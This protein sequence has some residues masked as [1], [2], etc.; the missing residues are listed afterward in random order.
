MAIAFA[1]CWTALPPPRALAETFKWKDEKGVTHISSTPP[2][3]GATLVPAAADGRPGAKLSTFAP[4]Y[5]VQLQ[6]QGSYTVDVALAPVEGAGGRTWLEGSLQVWVFGSERHLAVIA[7]ASA[8]GLDPAVGIDRD[9]SGVL[10]AEEV[11]QPG[12]TWAVQD[13]VVE[14][15]AHNPP[16]PTATFTVSRSPEALAARSP[17]AS[18]GDEEESLAGALASGAPAP[19][20]DQA[21]LEGRTVSIRDYRGKVLLIDFW[22]T[23]CGPCRRDVPELVKVYRRF[24][25]R[26]FEIVGVSLDDQAAVVADFIAKE[27]MD[28]PQICDGNGFSSELARR[29]DVNAIPS[30]FLVDPDGKLV[31]GARLHGPSAV[32]EEVGRLLGK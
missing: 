7:G 17:V 28:W 10:E 27:G 31:R 9:R 24:Q 18:R 22:A 5:Y 21:D 19:A 2:P 11:M 16:A 6:D 4:S 20:L 8:A 15:V 1:W 23:W 14:L 3:A 29:Y 25:H 12:A 30:V 32:A 13:I 26:G